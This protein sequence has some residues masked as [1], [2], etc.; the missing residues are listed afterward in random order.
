MATGNL[1][2]NRPDHTAAFLNTCYEDAIDALVASL[3]SGLTANGADLNTVDLNESDDAACDIETPED[4]LAYVA[5][6][7]MT[8]NMPSEGNS[9]GG[10]MNTDASWIAGWKTVDDG[11]GAT[12]GELRFVLDIYDFLE[13]QYASGVGMGITSDGITPPREYATQWV[14]MA[15]RISELLKDQM[16]FFGNQFVQNGA[17]YNTA[18][19]GGSIPLDTAIRNA[20]NITASANIGQIT[21]ISKL[22]ITTKLL[23]F[24]TQQQYQLTSGGGN[25]QNIPAL[26]GGNSNPFETLRGFAPT[27]KNSVKQAT[28]TQ[29]PLSYQGNQQQV[30]FN[31]DDAQTPVYKLFIGQ[32]ERTLIGAFAF[33]VTTSG[34]SDSFNTVSNVYTPDNSAL[35]GYTGTLLSLED[36]EDAAFGVATGTD[37]A[38]ED[39]EDPEYEV[40]GDDQV[41]IETFSKGFSQGSRDPL[42][43][44]LDCGSSGG[45][46]GTFGE[47]ISA[48]I[49]G[50]NQAFSTSVLYVANSLRVFRNGQRQG[51]TEIT[52]TGSS[53]FSTTFV[54]S[55]GEVLIIDYTP[56]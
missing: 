28:V 52:E 14:D 31:T 34:G 53:T 17:V 43:R 11:T 5:Y 4:I 32:D 41:S 49:N 6:L 9:F 45:A 33:T 13:N 21:D 29:N 40:A 54:A 47:D 36:W 55:V 27:F 46:G 39:Y 3:P 48:Q 16:M 8:Y 7:G 12:L 26:S 1:T 30:S 2:Q 23:P 50:S 35:G 37:V 19:V 15:T 24:Q 42:D 20:N 38:T 25:P 18:R 51:P 44:P 22:A 56:Q 10:E